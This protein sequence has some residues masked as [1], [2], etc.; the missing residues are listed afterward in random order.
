[1]GGRVAAAYC[2]MCEGEATAVPPF[3]QARIADG[4]VAINTINAMPNNLRM[5]H[6]D[7]T[8]LFNP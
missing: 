7:L 5:I 4:G 3:P 1:M 6:P 8:G 2:V